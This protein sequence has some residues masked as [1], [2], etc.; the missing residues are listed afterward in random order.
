[1]NALQ[2]IPI[3]K[4]RLGRNPR[5][6]FDEMKLQDLAQSIQARGQQQPIV[7]E[8]YKGG[9]ILVMGERRLRAHKL[10]GRTTIQAYVRARTN[11]SG[12]ERFLDSLIEND[13][14]A[15]M[16]AMETARAYATLQDEFGMTAREISKKIGKSETVIGNLLILNRLDAEIQGM[17]DE[18]LWHDP[19]FVRGLLQIEDTTTRVELAR[20]LWAHRVSLKG[21]LK[22]V[23]EAHRLAIR[24]AASRKI[25]IRKGSPARQLAEA[26]QKPRRWGMLQQLRQLPA[27]ELVVHA[28]DQT[29][30]ACPLRS[31]ASQV[32]CEDCGAVTLLRK[33]MEA[34]K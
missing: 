27:W 23:S 31:M 29:C 4:I 20:R 14:R 12:R 34:A 25:D 24:L 15:D 5:K 8:P 18:G 2:D 32:T 22:A 17:I 19:R 7:L 3:E 1:M 13:Q 10:L 28:A 6:K 11:H 21:C 16:T 33:M 9:F 30:D 26:D